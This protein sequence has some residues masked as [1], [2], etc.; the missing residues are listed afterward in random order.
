MQAAVMHMKCSVMAHPVLCGTLSSSAGLAYHGRL[1]PSA[2]GGDC[3]LWQ[4]PAQ[5]LQYCVVLPCEA[6]CRE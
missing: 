6:C 1:F 5:G 4:T 3:A 2:Y